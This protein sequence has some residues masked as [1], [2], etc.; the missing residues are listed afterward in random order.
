MKF[1]T[2]QGHQAIEIAKLKGESQQLL[3]PRRVSLNNTIDNEFCQIF[4]ELNLKAEVK[5]QLKSHRNASKVSTGDFIN[6]KFIEEDKAIDFGNI[7]HVVVDRLN[8]IVSEHARSIM[9]SVQTSNKA[10][11]N[12]LTNNVQEINH[13]HPCSLVALTDMVELI[14]PPHKMPVTPP[15]LAL[16]GN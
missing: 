6:F 12:I 3:S 11:W 13:V 7:N 14:F 16:E 5:P 10:P 9:E 4:T 15:L 2:Q 1:L 8:Q